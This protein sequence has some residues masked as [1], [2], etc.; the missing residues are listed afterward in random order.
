MS[1]LSQAT[2]NHGR[3][4]IDNELVQTTT[5][6]H[7][8]TSLTALEDFPDD[9]DFYI[10]TL[11][12]SSSDI[13]DDG[14]FVIIGAKGTDDTCFDY[15]CPG[16]VF[17][18]RWILGEWAEDAVL[19]PPSF[20]SDE[21]K[22][23]LDQVRFGESVAINGK[24]ALVSAPYHGGMDG[25]VY[26]YRNI[27]S[28]QDGGGSTSRWEHFTTIVGEKDEFLGQSIGLD[29]D[30]DDV[31]IVGASE[32]DE[33]RGKA[34]VYSIGSDPA[35]KLAE[36]APNDRRPDDRFGDAVDIRGEFAIVGSPRHDIDGM[37][38]M[39]AA[40]IFRKMPLSGWV[41]VE[42]LEPF[43]GLGDREDNFGFSVAIH[44]DLAVV[45]APADSATDETN[46]G[47]AYVFRKVTD[48]NSGEEKW[49][50]DAHLYDREDAN[51][52]DLFGKAVAV[53]E[54][55][56]FF[57][58]PGRDKQKYIENSGIGYFFR[59]EGCLWVLEDVIEPDDLKGYRAIGTSVGLGASGFVVG[60]IDG[61]AYVGRFDEEEEEEVKPVQQYIEYIILNYEPF[62]ICLLSFLF[63]NIHRN[64]TWKNHKS[65]TTTT[66]TPTKKTTSTT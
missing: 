22:L 5:R 43:G 36:L 53:Y 44:E 23:L 49:I 16:R 24:F 50:S 56:I 39:G 1:L 13:S 27:P 48:G 61:I 58:A 14:Q 7:I 21:E 11:Y 15:I 65:T 29:G 2:L 51:R 34:Y 28:T 46:F 42:K 54:N 33:K 62:L 57:G 19:R 59:E 4:S 32:F 64:Q 6:N 8:Y 30:N 17:I 20:A 3:Q 66:T 25:R 45:G 26:V 12:G 55:R 18:Y 41:Q 63:T 40:Y 60:G 47:S 10:D 35:V 38:N 52:G 37:E 31:A 9:D